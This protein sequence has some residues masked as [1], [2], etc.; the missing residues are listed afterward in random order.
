MSR[1]F[2]HRPLAQRLGLPEDQLAELEQIL[3]ALYLG[4]EMMVELRMLRTVM[5][6]EG[7]GT[8]L[9]QAISEFREELETPL[10]SNNSAKIA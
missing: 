9:P 5:A 7:G 8:T 10:P 4:D 2:D 3:R 1:S 6:V